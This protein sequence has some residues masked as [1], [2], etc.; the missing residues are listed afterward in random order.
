VSEPLPITPTAASAT[1]PVLAASLL[2]AIQREL[3]ILPPG[4]AFLN[5]YLVDTGPDADDFDLTQANAAYVYD[6]ALAGLFLLAAG[7]TANAR[8][9]ADALAFAQTHDRFYRD[10]RLRNAYQAG[11]VSNP[12][13]LPGWWDKSA[14]QWREDPYQV[15]TQTG[16]MA[17]AILL[18]T[19]LGMTAPAQA[20]ATWLDHNLRAPAGYYGGL[21]GFE[22][23]PLKLTWQSTEQNTDMAVAAAR[24]HRPADAASAAAFVHSRFDRAR[25]L[26]TAGANPNA[27]AN[28]LIAADAGIWPYLAG[29]SPAAPALSAITLLTRTES[30][31]TGIGFSAASA[32]I[33]LEGTAFAAL[34][35]HEANDSRR[36][37]FIATLAANITPQGYINATIAPTLATGLTTGPSLIPGQPETPFT[38]RRRPALSTT[39]WAGLSALA[40]NPL[41]GG[42]G[43][44][45]SEQGQG[46]AAP[47]DPPPG[48]RPGAH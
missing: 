8:R 26:F 33:W 16:P 27:T 28:P 1:T 45:V 23:S 43:G 42:F 44:Y 31:L 21:Y 29:L 25:D 40:V 7:D 41:G 38:Y 46:G 17:W 30:G 24:L 9:L 19:A 32:G 3:S 2:A 11:P 6:Q 34:A 12:V 47:L 22:Q 39:A 35:L 36:K 13:K 48:K 37:T 18:W 15:S 10:G 20:A 14:N 5:S 4:P